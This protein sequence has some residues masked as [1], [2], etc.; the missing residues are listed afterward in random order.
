M[1]LSTPLPLL[2]RCLTGAAALGASGPA[3]ALAQEPDVIDTGRFEIRIAAGVAGTE[4]FAIRSEGERITAVGRISVVPGRGEPFRVGFTVG[5]D[6]SLIQY[7][8][9]SRTENGPRIEAVPLGANRLQLTTQGARGE[10]VKE[11]VAPPAI[12]IL[13]DGVAHHYYFLARRVVAANS[14]AG[15]ALRVL[16]PGRGQVIRATITS[17]SQVEAEVDGVSRPAVRIDLTIGGEE[18]SVWASQDGSRLIRVLNRSTG[19]EARRLSEG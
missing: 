18:H 5:A 8:L 6:F 4:V 3:L 1:N 10:R 19:W 13:E 15:D 14:Q 7:D 12:L 17:V 9:R 11:V 2:I 16:V